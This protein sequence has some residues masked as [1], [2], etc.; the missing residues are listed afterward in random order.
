[1]STRDDLD[2]SSTP[3]PHSI[4]RRQFLPFLGLSAAAL[5]APRVLGQTRRRR[6]NAAAR[7]VYVGTYTGTGRSARRDASQYGDRNIGVPDGPGKRRFHAHRG[8]PG[9]ES[10]VPGTRPALT[11]LYSINENLVGGVSAYAVQGDRGT[12]SPSSTRCRR[13]AASPAHLSVHPSGQTIFSPPT[14][15]RAIF[16]SFRIQPDGSIGAQTADFQSVRATAPA[17]IQIAR[18]ARTRTRSSPTRRQLT[19]SASTW[20]RTRSTSW[21]LDLGDGRR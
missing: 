17:P 16:R 1:M 14:I 3:T 5:A 4:T 6:T 13:T 2:A 9:L 7:F 19:C 20:A 18:K 8:G 15:R 12:L 21:T 11:H 10:V